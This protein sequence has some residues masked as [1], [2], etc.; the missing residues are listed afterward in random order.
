MAQTMKMVILFTLQCF[1]MHPLLFQIFDF[2]CSVINHFMQYQDST[3]KCTFWNLGIHQIIPCSFCIL[4]M[5][6][7]E[8]LT[9][10]LWPLRISYFL[11]TTP[12][13]YGN[14]TGRLFVTWKGIKKPVFKG[15][16]LIHVSWI[17]WA[18][19]VWLCL[20]WVGFPK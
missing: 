4:D 12:W 2:S 19:R 10:C 5:W 6:A 7:F 1:I 8:V 16:V 3:F 9:C 20:F 17:L 18:S 15:W 13:W 14:M 11:R